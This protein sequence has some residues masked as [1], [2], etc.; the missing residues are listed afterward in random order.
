MFLQN[1][2]IL[3]TKEIIASF[4]KHT[5]SIFLNISKTKIGSTVLQ[6]LVDWKQNYLKFSPNFLSYNKQDSN[7][8]STNLGHSI[9]LYLYIHIFFPKYTFQKIV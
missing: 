5:F 4:R 6:H 1:L 9:Y 8:G 7:S 2:K 3:Q